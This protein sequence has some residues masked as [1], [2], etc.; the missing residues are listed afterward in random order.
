MPRKSKQ[1]TPPPIRTWIGPRI[2]E[3]R[4]SL[5]LT[6]IELAARSGIGQTV[7][8]KYERGLREPPLSQLERIARGLGL[9]LEQ[10]VAAS[11]SPR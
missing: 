10:F 5:G 11:K 2:R 4:E 8:S 9:P 6:Q 1:S 7:L 3:I